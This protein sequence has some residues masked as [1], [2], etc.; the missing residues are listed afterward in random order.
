MIQERTKNVILR[1]KNTII[2]ESIT[3]SLQIHAVAISQT[4][5]TRRRTSKYRAQLVV[6]NFILQV[7]QNRFSSAIQNSPPDA[8][9]ED[10]KKQI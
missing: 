3:S 4:C 7:V 10:V 1:S 9:D 6:H 5:K 8:G 2:K